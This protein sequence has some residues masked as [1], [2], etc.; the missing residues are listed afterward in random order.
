MG[1]VKCRSLVGL[2]LVQSVVTA[3]CILA[4]WLYVFDKK[5]KEEE[6]V[7]WNKEFEQQKAD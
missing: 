4:V 7:Q 5:E 3:I 1:S 6:R 2:K